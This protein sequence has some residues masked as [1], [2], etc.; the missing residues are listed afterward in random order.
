[1]RFSGLVVALVVAACD[2]PA[3]GHDAGAADAA[4]P[5]ATVDG[6]GASGRFATLDDALASG[7]ARICLEAGDFAPPSE[8]ITRDV[9]IEGLGE[10]TRLDGSLGCV[11]VSIPRSVVATERRDATAGLAVT[12]GASV[13]LRRLTLRG[14]SLAALVLDGTLSLTDV[15]ARDAAL[16][17]LAV[18]PSSTLAIDSS[19]VLARPIAPGFGTTFAGAIGALEG[20]ALSVERSEV[21]GAAGTIDVVALGARA[22]RLSGLDIV[23]GMSGFYVGS[24]AEAV[25]EDVSVSALRTF[26]DG[27]LE[28]FAANAVQGGSARITRLTV[29]DIE[30]YGLVAREGAVVEV[31]ELRATG[32]ESV[33]IIAR[34]GSRLVVNGAQLERVGVGI[35]AEADASA[36]LRGEISVSETRGAVVGYTG[37]TITMAEGASLT[38]RDAVLGAFADVGAR[39]ALRSTRVTDSE[40][41]ASARGTLELDATTID[42]CESGVVTF[43]GTTTASD[44]TISGASLLAMAAFDGSTMAIERAT[45]TE[46]GPLWLEGAEHTLT[47]V[48]V[49]RAREQGVLVTDGAS[50]VMS[51]GSVRDGAGRGIEA[52]SGSVVVVDGTTASGNSGAAIAFYDASGEIRSSTFGGTR[53]DATGRADEIRIVAARGTSRRVVIESNTFLLDVPRV[54][55][56]GACALVVG[57]GGDAQGIVRPN[58]LVASPGGSEIHT[59]VDQNG[60][61]MSLEGDTGWSTLLLGRASEVGL[62]TG[63]VGALPPMV[64]APAAPTLPMAG[65]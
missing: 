25:L 24:D 1:M 3:G 29:D 46:S 7:A 9:E 23:G 17:L 37:G 63:T 44:L 20:A 21:Q 16:T 40:L 61:T 33:A 47:D 12:E 13:S 26:R 10:D 32:T 39:V 30:G 48:D 60:A 8:P 57:D 59:V 65:I 53:L 41:A 11:N 19:R 4:V 28:S 52:Q 54:C 5:C 15:V 18:G 58:C 64:S 62:D 22:V 27:D 45:L 14:C 36:E 6:R 56:A 35:G 49:V 50:V 31:S 43:G 55:V 34:V 42:G 2:P 38:V 51:R